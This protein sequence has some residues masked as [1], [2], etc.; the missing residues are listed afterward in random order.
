MISSFL[1]N[2]DGNVLTEQDLK[3]ER[4]HRYRSEALERAHQTAQV[5]ARESLI[6]VSYRLRSTWPFAKTLVRF[7][8]LVAQV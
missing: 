1:F 6:I 7:S 3:A 5:R 8:S 2:L 4:E